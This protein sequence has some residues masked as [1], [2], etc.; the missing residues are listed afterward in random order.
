MNKKNLAMA[1]A[2]V[3]V[4]GSAAPI[5]ADGTNYLTAQD[6]LDGNFKNG[7]YVKLSTEKE[8]KI[9][10]Y[11]VASSKVKQI[12]NDL[13][14]VLDNGGKIVARYKEMDGD[15]QYKVIKDEFIIEDSSDLDAVES[16][17]K[18]LDAG[19]FVDFEIQTQE[20][21]KYTSSEI[22]AL[23]TT[24]KTEIDKATD[25]VLF[26][27]GFK[28]LG[29][30]LV[31]GTSTAVNTFL[32]TNYYNTASGATVK[33]TDD[34]NG[35]ILTLPVAATPTDKAYSDEDGT[36][37]VIVEDINVKTG[38]AKLDFSKPYVNV[39]GKLA[40][41][42]EDKEFGTKHY[43]RV[44]KATE[45]NVTVDSDSED[46]AKNLAKQY[47]FNSNDIQDAIDSLKDAVKDG[48][49]YKATLFSTG[50]RLQGFATYGASSKTPSELASGNSPVVL[51]AKS[52]SKS[53]LKDFLEDLKT[54]NNSYK[55]T[56]VV[57]GEDRIETAIAISE[58]YFNST[59]NGHVTTNEVD[60][61]VL[62]GSNAIVD[63]LVAAPLASEKTAPLLLTGKDKLDSGVKAEIKRVMGLKTS[64]GVSNKK[65]VYIAGGVNSVS[66]DVEKDLT[67][68]GLK[69]TRL[70]GEDRYET[71]LK[72]AD[73]IGLDND[74]AYVVGG[75]GLADAMSVAS[76]A[77]HLTNG[78]ADPIIVVDGKGTELSSDAEDFLG[79][80]EVDIIGGT[81]S[82]S[83][84]MEKSIE[85]AIGQAPDR[86]KGNDRQGTNAEVIKKYYKID[87]TDAIRDGKGAKDFFVAKD[88]ST[89]EDQ[90]VDALAIGAVAG[91]NSA[92]V[93][94]ATDSISSEQSVAISKVLEDDTDA[95]LTQIGKGIAESVL[96][97]MKDL[98]D[99]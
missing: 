19:E 75:T 41:R 46:V 42:A 62:V 72:I 85:D 37:E 66:K 68:M 5:F 2:A 67:D 84:E 43:L 81:A 14:K 16:K 23:A 76:V 9:K 59:E 49:Y 40:F 30:N 53:D 96:N 90:L 33:Y 26:E 52:T 56:N 22:D 31:D 50:K 35:R 20:S 32:T 17:I 34:D 55:N 65:T 44:V 39:L 88:G 91:H 29:A 82:V 97:R 10:G 3:T 87:D 71:S 61:V 74:K 24:I 27:G 79:S 63:G 83:K 4:V 12:K 80:A 93:V 51:T 7:D 77:S 21:P 11:T 36:K 95:S 1:M 25:K 38:D 15:N 54:Y 6:L 98:L 58:K 89:K 28:K 73:K 60:N 92:P 78:D 69:V 86:V 99:L 64:D 45:K 13:Q 8:A 47:V 57:A 94:L 70:S 18:D 48:D